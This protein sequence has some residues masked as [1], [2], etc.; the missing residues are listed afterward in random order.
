MNARQQAPLA[1]FVDDNAGRES[2]AQRETFALERRQCTRHLSCRDAE[3]GR[4]RLLRYRAQTF[5]A[6]A[7][8]LNQRFLARPFSLRGAVW[9]F[10][11][12]LD[13]RVRPDGTKLGHALGG[14]PQRVHWG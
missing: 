4:E 14:D 11:C 1:P 10:N 12:R 9:C 13:Q 8:D 7:H 2:T 6:A 3:R 5:E